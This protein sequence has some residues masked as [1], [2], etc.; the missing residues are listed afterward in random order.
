[1]A[2]DKKK[3][4]ILVSPSAN[5]RA[6][7]HFEFMAR[8]SVATAERLLDTLMKDMYALDINPAACPPYDRPFITK[9]KYRYKLSAKRYRIVFTI[10][11]DIIFVDD[12]EDCRQDD[13]KSLLYIEENEI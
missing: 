12:I 6:N 9:N 10:E 4:Q 5:D 2:T 13:D 8:V 1:M 3:Y 7:E 11:D